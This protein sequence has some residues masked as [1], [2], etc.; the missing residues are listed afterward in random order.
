MEH[1]KPVMPVFYQSVMQWAATKNLPPLESALDIK[2]R[3]RNTNQFSQ[4]QRYTLDVF[5]YLANLLSAVERL[6]EIQ[7][8]IGGFPSR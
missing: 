2:K 8:Y 1:L 7:V 3:E 6:E 5:G 4:A